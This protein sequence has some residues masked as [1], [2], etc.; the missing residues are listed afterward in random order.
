LAVG[1]FGVGDALIH[2]LDD[3]FGASGIVSCRLPFSKLG[4]YSADAVLQ[5][6]EIFAGVEITGTPSVT[7]FRV[8]GY[9]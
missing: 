5:V 8:V 4:H 7:I 1:G 2:P 9:L 6:S 3:V